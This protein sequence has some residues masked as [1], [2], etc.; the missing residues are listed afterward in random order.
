MPSFNFDFRV[1]KKPVEKKIKSTHNDGHKRL[2]LVVN[3]TE[4]GL[5]F[6]TDNNVDYEISL[7]SYNC[8]NSHEV[9][10]TKLDKGRIIRYSNPGSIIGNAKN[11]IRFIPGNTVKGY[12]RKNPNT[13]KEEFYVESVLLDIPLNRE[14]KQKFYG[15]FEKIINYLNVKLKVIRQSQYQ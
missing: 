10:I 5:F 4:E 9:Y 14:I 13:L 1:V 2:S 7:N 6:V 11:Y 12:I 15:N 8:A 3:T